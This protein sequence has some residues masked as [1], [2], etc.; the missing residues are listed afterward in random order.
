MKQLIFSKCSPK[1]TRDGWGKLPLRCQL[2]FMLSMGYAKFCM[3]ETMHS[4][5]LDISK[6]FP[7]SSLLDG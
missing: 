7:G 2:E 6:D 4:R 1:E 3:G 5:Y